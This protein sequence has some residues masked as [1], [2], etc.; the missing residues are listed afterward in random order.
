M[1]KAQE[2]ALGYATT[3]VAASQK[4]SC[5]LLQEGPGPSLIL[6]KKR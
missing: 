6:N 3:A 5:V 4:A 1:S 2:V